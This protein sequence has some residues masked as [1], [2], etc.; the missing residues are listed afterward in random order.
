M[1]EANR[2]MAAAVVVTTPAQITLTGLAFDHIDVLVLAGPGADGH[3]QD[4]QMQQMW[5]MVLPH[6]SHIV[7]LGPRAQAWL[8]APERLAETSAHCQL[9]DDR[10]PA[11]LATIAGLMRAAA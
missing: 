10:G 11:M 1:L 3:W 2:D 8:P 4:A 5:A 7:V 6:I 9:A